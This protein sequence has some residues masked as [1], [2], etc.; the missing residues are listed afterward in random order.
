MV[1]PGML[2]AVRIWIVQ[3]LIYVQLVDEI[4]ILANDQF[5]SSGASGGT[6]SLSSF[7]PKENVH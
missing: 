5:Q 4:R 7:A 6:S 1:F 3:S 2:D